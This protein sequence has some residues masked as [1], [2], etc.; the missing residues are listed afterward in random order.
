MYVGLAY[1]PNVGH[2]TCSRDDQ[3]RL[4]SFD[5][6]PAIIH[7]SGTQMWYNHGKLHRK[8][9]PAVEYSYRLFEYWENGRF[10]NTGVVKV[11]VT[12]SHDSTKKYDI[13]LFP[14]LTGVRDGKNKKTPAQ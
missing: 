1:V 9:A 11:L 10:I 4:H 5:D 2:K 7:L 8:D 12:D 14:A 3:G 6:E 13:G